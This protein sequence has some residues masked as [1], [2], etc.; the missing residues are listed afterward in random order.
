V[1]PKLKYWSN[2]FVFVVAYKRR[3]VCWLV[4]CWVLSRPANLSILFKSIRK[5]DIRKRARTRPPH[6]IET[7]L[8]IGL[9]KGISTASTDFPYSDLQVGLQSGRMLVGFG[10]I[11]TVANTIQTIEG[12]FPGSL[13]YRNNNPGNLTFAN[14]A[15]ATPVQVCNPMCHTFASFDSYA[16][17]YAA[18]ENQISL[19][20]SRGES[21]QDFINKYAPAS[22]NN[23]PTSYAAQIAAA[24]GLSVNDPLSSALSGSPSALPG[25][26]PSGSPLGVDPSLLASDSTVSDVFTSDTGTVNLAG[27]DIPTTYVWIGAS[28][29]LLLAWQ[30]TR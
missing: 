13:S 11:S 27:V 19:D 7:D 3:K 20:A 26:P 28:L 21:I 9:S 10:D 18:L 30:A 24:T 29:A 14:Q 5:S 17:G 23:N 22:D 2:G 25:V 1:Y 4:A 8:H 15:G 6:R 16:S 12:W